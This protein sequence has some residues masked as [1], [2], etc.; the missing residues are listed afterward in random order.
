MFR[1]LQSHLTG[2]QRS[3]IC[4][5]NKMISKM[6]FNMLISSNHKGENLKL[7]HNSSARILQ[8]STANE[9][10]WEKGRSQTSRPLFRL[11]ENYERDLLKWILHWQDLNFILEDTL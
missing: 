1:R 10:R 2:M 6:V 8:K 7:R 9:F 4:Y 3:T 11:T 5:T